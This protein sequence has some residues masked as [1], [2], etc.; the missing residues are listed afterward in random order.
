M[1]GLI[2]RTLNLF[3]RHRSARPRASVFTLARPSS[4]SGEPPA[5]I[6]TQLSNVTA[7]R[8]LTAA[9]M[10]TNH[11]AFKGNGFRR[12]IF[13][14]SSRETSSKP[15]ADDFNRRH[16][17]ILRESRSATFS[18]TPG[19]FSSSFCRRESIF[20]SMTAQAALGETRR[21]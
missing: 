9:Y 11:L 6:N 13:W 10:A 8:I 5:E 15:S 19:R 18:R 17:W 4:A 12:G 3:C 20:S 2:T 1:S 14:I 16:R 7:R 21:R